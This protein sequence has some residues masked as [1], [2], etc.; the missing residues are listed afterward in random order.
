M[1]HLLCLLTAMLLIQGN[2]S[3]DAGLKEVQTTLKAQGFYFG[4]TDGKENAE[5]TAAI[6]R[7]QIRNGLEVTGKLNTATLDALGADKASPTPATSPQVSPAVPATASPP[8]TPPPPAPAVTAKPAQPLPPKAEE[9]P[10]PANPT[11]RAIRLRLSPKVA[12]TDAEEYTTFF[13][14]TPY[15]TAPKQVQAETVRRAQDVLVQENFLRGAVGG[16]PDGSTADAIFS[17]QIE[18]KLTR[19]GRLDKATLATLGLLPQAQPSKAPLKPF[20]ETFK[21]EQ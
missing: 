3:A 14:G 21:R 15:A 11:T 2:V 17:Y 13:H 9:Q 10:K 19:T 1:K 18:H 16:V 4:E 6:R 20:Y 8:A 5:T 7:F 12:E